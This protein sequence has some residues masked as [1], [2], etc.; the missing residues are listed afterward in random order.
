MQTHNETITQ[1]LDTYLP[2]R[3][4]ATAVERLAKKKIEVSK[5]VVR[6][7]RNG[8]NTKNR[9]QI[10]SVLVEIATEER[11][12]IQELQDFISPSS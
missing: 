7:A 11:D 5:D 6:N 3:Y 9:N 8:R 4:S 12:A 10:I 2:T 1:L